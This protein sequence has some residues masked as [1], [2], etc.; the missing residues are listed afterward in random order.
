MPRVTVVLTTYNRDSVVGST[1]EAVLAQTYKDFELI[2][3]DDC[4]TDKT[5][6]ICLEYER[7]DQR[8][9]YRRNERNAGMPGNLNTAIRAANGEYIAN[10]HDGDIYHP[11]LLEKWV[12]ALDT[13]PKAGFV[14]NAYRALDADGKERAIYRE[15]LPPC[16]EGSLLLEA[17]FFKRWRFDSPVWGTVMARRSAY[18]EVGLFDDRFG[19]CSDV[20]MWMRLADRFHVAYI[21]EPLISLPSREVLP[22]R[23]TLESWELQKKIERMFWEGRMRHYRGQ[24]LR[25]WRAM[26]THVSQVLCARTWLLVLRFRSLLRQKRGIRKVLRSL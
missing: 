15:P 13:C 21:N 3:S 12:A 8:I 7:R 23:D 2:I 17:I 14:F 22:R 16:A 20:D 1:I 6:Q 11:A 5:E 26:T 18:E 9:R 24:P 25:R 10:L 19:F 4:S